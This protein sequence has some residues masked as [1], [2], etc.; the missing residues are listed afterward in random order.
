MYK[1][2]VLPLLDRAKRKLDRTQ[3]SSL[4]ERWLW[5]RRPAPSWQRRGAA[6]GAFNV[7]I[8]PRQAPVGAKRVPPHAL[9]EEDA[10]RLAPDYIA[11]GMGDISTTITMPLRRVLALPAAGQSSGV[12]ALLPSVR[13]VSRRHLRVSMPMLL[14]REVAMLC[15]LFS[16]MLIGSLSPSLAIHAVRVT[17]VRT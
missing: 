10:L 16:L 14:P 5:R 1:R 13:I 7:T 12:L 3:P 17:V 9:G 11:A 2:Q 15:V 8:S 4:W 6:L